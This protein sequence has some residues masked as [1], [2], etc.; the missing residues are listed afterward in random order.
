MPQT[1]F[2]LSKAIEAGPA[3]R[4]G[5]QVRPSDGRIEEVINEVSRPAWWNWGRRPRWT[6][7]SCSRR[8][9]AGGARRRSTRPR[10]P[11]GHD[12]PPANP[13]ADMRP[14]FD[15]I[16]RH[17][18]AAGRP[19]AAA[20]ASSR[21]WTTARLRQSVSASGG[22]STGAIRSGQ[23]VVS[24]K[25]TAGR[26]RRS[27][28][29][30]VPGAG[31]GWRR[32][33]CTRATHAR[34]WGPRA[35]G[36]R[37]HDLRR[38]PAGA[39]PPGEGGRADADDGVPRERLAV[40]RAGRTYV[41]SQQIRE[42]LDKELQSN[43]GAAGG[44]GDR[45]DEFVV[46]GGLLHL[47]ILLER[48]C[49]EGSSCRWANRRSSS[50][51]ST[52]RQH[53]PI[54]V[55]RGGRAERHRRPVDGTHR[56]AGRTQDDGTARRL[57]QTTWFKIPRGRSSA[58]SSP[59]SPPARAGDHAR[60][61]ATPRRQRNAPREDTSG[62]ASSSYRTGGGDTRANCS[63]TA[64]CSSSRRATRSARAGSSGGQ[65]RQ[66]LPVVV[67][68]PALKRLDVRGDGWSHHSSSEPAQMGLGRASVHRGR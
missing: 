68:I 1:R 24:V 15:A 64:A 63:P 8:G 4:G 59:F 29:C 39:L 48:R 53:E 16:V 54:G 23:Q 20:D 21:R 17:V 11:R 32:T 42:R 56:C 37:R 36:H 44:G 9:A 49:G 61:Q 10:P 41:T 28:N 25:M 2:V 30:S 65:S 19:S 13:K 7:P 50:N 43:V 31:D 46:S 12:H 35:G 22:C 18:P 14:I 66:R 5:E 3:D 40:C 33:R 34:W 47:G 62:R 6:S 60:V 52:A 51:R 27:R 55:A 57:R 38:G 45:G 67:N 58:C 26:S